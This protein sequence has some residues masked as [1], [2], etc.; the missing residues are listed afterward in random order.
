MT[1]SFV[2]LPW[3]I[4][5][6]NMDCWVSIVNLDSENRATLADLLIKMALASSTL[7]KLIF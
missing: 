4:L 5:V 1:F 6:L 7:T 2:R 3:D